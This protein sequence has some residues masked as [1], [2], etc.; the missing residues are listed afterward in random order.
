MFLLSFD[1][2]LFQ[3]LV[4]PSSRKGGVL[5]RCN[6]FAEERHFDIHPSL[7]FFLLF[8]LRSLSLSLSPGNH[9]I[10]SVIYCLGCCSPV[11]FSRI[12]RTL[13]HGYKESKGGGG[14]LSSLSLSLSRTQFSNRRTVQGEGKDKDSR[15]SKGL[16]RRTQM[17]DAYVSNKE[18]IGRGT[19]DRKFLITSID[20]ERDETI[21]KSGRCV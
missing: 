15:G 16:F 3:D 18:I 2:S 5:S 17:T 7:R 19:P 12:P 13:T 11:F 1:S 21:A 9:V 14:N 6:R 8:I 20:Q 10:P 4:C